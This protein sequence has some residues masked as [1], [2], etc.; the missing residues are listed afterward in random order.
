VGGATCG[1]LARIKLP[2]LI[3][4]EGM[5]LSVL[6]ALVADPAMCNG[7]KVRG[8]VGHH[9]IRCLP[10]GD[11]RVIFWDIGEITLSQSVTSPTW[12]LGIRVGC[13]C[14]LYSW[15]SRVRSLKEAFGKGTCTKRP[16]FKSIRASQRYEL[17]LAITTGP[18]LAAFRR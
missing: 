1:T 18:P 7:R 16:P 3:V 11:S 8:P 5:M 10:L 6:S 15:P 17:A 12:K 4:Y 2:K 9:Q 14:R 13:M